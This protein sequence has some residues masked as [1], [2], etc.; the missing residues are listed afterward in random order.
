MKY[1]KY[2][3]G[4]YRSSHAN[5]TIK[6]KWF[7]KICLR[8]ALKICSEQIKTV[9]ELEKKFAKKC[10][11]FVTM[12][13]ILTIAFVSLV[14][15]QIALAKEAE[16]NAPKPPKVSIF[17]MTI[18]CSN[19][20][21]VTFTEVAKPDGKGGIVVEPPIG[22]SLMGFNIRSYA[23]DPKHEQRI[24]SILSSLPELHTEEQINAYINSK[25]STSPIT[26]DM[27]IKACDEYNVPIDLVIAIIQQ[28]SSF[29][30]AG[31]GARTNNPGNVGNTDSGATHSYSS[32]ADGIRGVARWL[33]NHRS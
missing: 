15:T 3:M 32:W 20:E 28:D 23:T 11:Y 33:N 9:K 31:L 22:T 17:D 30:T 5:K 7:E 24:S 25:A 14:N 27:I 2:P 26:A 21:P 4:I 13:W 10:F 8:F 18:I 29:G 19:C 12:A 6:L 1:V 16:Q